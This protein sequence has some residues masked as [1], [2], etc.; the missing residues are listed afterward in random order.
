MLEAGHEL[1]QNTLH[2][3]RPNGPGFFMSGD[4]V[5]PLVSSEQTGGQNSLSRI[6][7]L[8]GSGQ[9]LHRHAQHET[10]FILDGEVQF[11]GAR[12]GTIRNF[13]GGPGTLLHFPGCVPHSYFNASQHPATLL[14]FTTPGGLENFYARAGQQVEHGADTGQLTPDL[15]HIE[16]IGWEYGIEPIDPE[17][18]DA[19]EGYRA[20]SALFVPTAHGKSYLVLDSMVRI[21]ADANQTEGWLTVLEITQRPGGEAPQH[22]HGG[23]CT[24]YVLDG[25]F[26]FSGEAAEGRKSLAAGAGSALHRSAGM[27]YAFQNNAP[28]SSRMLAFVTPAGIEDFVRAVGRELKSPEEYYK[29]NWPAP[30]PEELSR[31]TA[32]ASQLGV[33]IH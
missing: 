30:T 22:R 4:I 9:G 5:Q 25:I 3:G 12:S 20:S 14:S 29:G 23:A 31:V 19:R 32:L 27:S 18:Y 13:A 10:L 2:S 6:T 28:T 16:T 11:Q 21:L 8:P 1:R 33:E 17:L 7:V 15:P 26:G 24:S